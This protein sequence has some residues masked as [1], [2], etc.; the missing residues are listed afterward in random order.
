MV[1][2]LQHEG[3]YPDVLLG[4]PFD[5]FQRFLLGAVAGRVAEERTVAL[6]VGGGLPVGNQQHLPRA[7]LLLAQQLP[8]QKQR[9]VQVGAG[10]PSIPA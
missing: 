8:R 3:V 2:V 9:M 6:Q 7:P 5:L 10:D 4:A 1:G